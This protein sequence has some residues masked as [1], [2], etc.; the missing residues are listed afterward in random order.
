[1]VLVKQIQPGSRRKPLRQW[2]IIETSAYVVV[3]VSLVTAAWANDH[4]S[5]EVVLGAWMVAGWIMAL[6]LRGIYRARRG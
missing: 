6:A 4:V 2:L 3:C 1:V 5:G